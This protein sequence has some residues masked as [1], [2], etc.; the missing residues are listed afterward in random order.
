M[1]ATT[2]T[3]IAAIVAADDSLTGDERRAIVARLNESAD[4]PRLPV[5]RIL[6]IPDTA[7][8]FNRSSRT[9]KAWAQAG[10]LQ[11]VILP[12]RKRACGFRQS[13]IERLIAG[14]GVSA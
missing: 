1:H 8:L 9:V 5:D 3:A 4:K 14:K 2:K 11:R 6:S 7:G 10:I 13:D 12:G